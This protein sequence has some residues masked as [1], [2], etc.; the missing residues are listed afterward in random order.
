MGFFYELE[1]EKRALLFGKPH[2][3]ITFAP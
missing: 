1:S 3:F 2:I